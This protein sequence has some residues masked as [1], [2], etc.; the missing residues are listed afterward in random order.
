L[1]DKYILH[2]V[3][4]SNSLKGKLPTGGVVFNIKIYKGVSAEDLIKEFSW[5]EILYDIEPNAI[6]KKMT[7][8]K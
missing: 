2:Q 5:I 6:Q 7:R 1:E 8:A 3:L 4:E